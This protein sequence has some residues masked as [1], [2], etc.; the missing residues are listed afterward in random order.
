MAQQGCIWAVL[1]CVGN[2]CNLLNSNDHAAVA[3]GSV[4][5]TG[6]LFRITIKRWGWIPDMVAITPTEV[7]AN[8]PLC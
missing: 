2:S 4:C 6:L 8:M 1:P 7:E 3:N 5:R